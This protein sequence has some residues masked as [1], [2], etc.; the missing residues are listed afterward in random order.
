M[1]RIGIN[2]MSSGLTRSS[3]PHVNSVGA[4][5]LCIRAQGMGRSDAAIEAIIAANAAFPYIRRAAAS[6]S[7][8]V[9]SVQ[10]SFD[11]LLG[12]Q[13]PVVDH[14]MQPVDQA[15]PGRVLGE[16]LEQ[17][18]SLAGAGGEDRG[19]DATDRDEAS[20]PFGCS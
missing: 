18:D 11:E 12:D 17:A 3:R 7:G 16:F 2:A 9:A 10:R 14:G 13:R 20:D 5:T 8:S 6:V 4:D 1:V 19:A 15:L